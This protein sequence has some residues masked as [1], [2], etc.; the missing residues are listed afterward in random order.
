M[1]KVFKIIIKNP[2][3]K[4]VIYDYPYYET[5]LFENVTWNFMNINDS[6]T[7]MRQQL[8][9]PQGIVGLTYTPTIRARKP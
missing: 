6:H 7:K 9:I 3:F 4:Y 1:E 5:A 2:T 8:I